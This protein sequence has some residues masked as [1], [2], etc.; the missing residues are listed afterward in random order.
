MTAEIVS[1]VQKSGSQLLFFDTLTASNFSNDELPT[2]CIRFH[3]R[4]VL[5]EI[6]VVPKHFRP[7]KGSRKN[8][9]VGQTS[10]NKFDLNLLIHKTLTADSAKPPEKRPPT[11]PLHPLT[12]SFDEKKGF[13][14]YD[15]T[16]LPEATTRFI[17]LRGNYQSVTLCI[18]GRVMESGKSHNIKSKDQLSSST[19]S[20]SQHN[21]KDNLDTFFLNGTDLTN[22]KQ[23]T[24][25]VQSSSIGNSIELKAEDDDSLGNISI[26]KE[27]EEKIDE[28]NSTRPQEFYNHDVN[29]M[30]NVQT[31]QS[32]PV[33]NSNSSVQ[34]PGETTEDQF[35]TPMEEDTFYLDDGHRDTNSDADRIGTLLN[36]DRVGT[37]RI[38]SPAKAVDFSVWDLD[39]KLSRDVLVYHTSP[40]ETLLSQVSQSVSKTMFKKAWDEFN[41]YV[42]QIHSFL[43]MMNTDNKNKMKFNS[44]TE[45]TSISFE[46]LLHQMNNVI[47]EGFLWAKHNEIRYDDELNT[48]YK[49]VLFALDMTTGKVKITDCFVFT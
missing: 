45:R 4:V 33:I 20:E 22:T 6:R 43:S 46:E 5:S 36:K 42:K 11:L 16:L 14:S 48:V 7:F 49:G 21:K 13:L 37:F 44:Y 31:E 2:E 15:V 40:D 19:I 3:Q 24:E 29:I 25:I 35:V 23:F 10:P 27:N 18:Y 34:I 17:I 26:K 8:D 41:N 12:I 32:I 38:L 39:D 30:D 28:M 9:H 1:S 47:V